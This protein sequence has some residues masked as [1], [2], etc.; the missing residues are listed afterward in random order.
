MFVCCGKK[1]KYNELNYLLIC[2]FITT[3]VWDKV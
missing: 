3:D 2:G 1:M